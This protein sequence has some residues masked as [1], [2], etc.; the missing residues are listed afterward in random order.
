MDVVFNGIKLL[1]MCATA[2][3]LSSVSWFVWNRRT[4]KIYFKINED[5][6]DIGDRS[7]T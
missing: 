3:M 5:Q 1:L 4:N 7:G 6:K 2:I